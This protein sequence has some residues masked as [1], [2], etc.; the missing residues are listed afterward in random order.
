MIAAPST[1]RASGDSDLV[2][3][4]GSAYAA[5]DGDPATAWTAPQRVVQHKTPEPWS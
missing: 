3:I 1:T 4:L 2:D 5:A